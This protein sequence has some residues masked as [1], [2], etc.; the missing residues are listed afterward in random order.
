MREQRQRRDRKHDRTPDGQ[1]KRPAYL[2]HNGHVFHQSADYM[3]LL[4]AHHERQ[5]NLDSS[6]AAQVQRQ[7]Q[8]NASLLESNNSPSHLALEDGEEDVFL[9]SNA[10]QNTTVLSDLSGDVRT[11]TG[12]RGRS[13]S[14]GSRHE[15]NLSIDM[16]PNRWNSLQRNKK[17]YIGNH[18]RGGLKCYRF[19]YH[20]V[21]SVNYTLRFA[22]AYLLM[23]IVMTY[24]VWFLVATVGGY[25]LGYF[26]FSADL[27]TAAARTE[28]AALT[29][30]MRRRR[31]EN[32]RPQTFY[33]H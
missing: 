15:R 1:S 18:S 16:D 14:R 22:M 10:T 30:R 23:L 11:L 12:D 3:E 2:Y 20:C 29:M 5:R 33:I 32:V 24:N 25:V 4:D 8:R 9:E 6:L 27:L 26:L 28:S 7:Q 31:L 17:G 21:Q 19:L 13:E